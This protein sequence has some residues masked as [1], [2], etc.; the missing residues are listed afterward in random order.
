[1]VQYGAFWYGEVRLGKAVRVLLG[2]AVLGKI[3]RGK[4]GT[5]WQSRQEAVS[6]V[7]VGHGAERPVKARI[8]SRGKIRC[9]KVCFV[10]LVCGLAV[11]VG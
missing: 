2:D 6:S 1:M 4:L 11:K 3:R 8:G 7:K 5:V 10:A 9:D